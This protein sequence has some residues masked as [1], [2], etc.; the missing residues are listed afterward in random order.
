MLMQLVTK[1]IEE[2]VQ[3]ENQKHINHIINMQIIIILKHQPVKNQGKFKAKVQNQPA[4]NLEQQIQDLP[5]KL[6]HMVEMES[7]I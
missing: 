4:R 3:M 2:K 1:K 7:R 5:M 6:A